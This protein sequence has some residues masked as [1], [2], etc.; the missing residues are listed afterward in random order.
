MESG[1]R[2][3][4]IDV[5]QVDLAYDKRSPVLNSLSLQLPSGSIYGLLGPSGCGKTSLIRCIL[6]LVRVDSG[7]IKVFNRKPNSYGSIVPGV[8][9][10]YMPQDISLF[11]DLSIDE[12]LLYFANLYGLELGACWKRIR[13][14][15]DFLN[16]P[17][18]YRSVGSLSGGQKRRVS[19]A[20]ALIHK[21]PLLIL[22]EPTVGV[23]PLLRTSI[24]SHLT[25]ISHI[26]GMTI[27]IT[28]HY[29]EEA[30]GAHLVGLMRNGRMLVQDNPNRLL[31]HYG[32]DTLEQVFLK[33]CTSA[34]AKRIHDD[35]SDLKQFPAS[36]MDNRLIPFNGESNNRLFNSIERTQSSTSSLNSVNIVKPSKPKRNE[37]YFYN[38]IGTIVKK[39]FRSLIRS[40]GYLL[41]QLLLPLV[42][43][44]LFA[45][46]IGRDLHSIPVAVFDG[47]QTNFSQTILQ[48]IDPSVIDQ[49][50]FQSEFEA[51][52]S[53][54]DGKHSQALIIPDNFAI[55]LY[56]KLND[57]N[58]INDEM[59]YNSTIRILPDMSNKLMID[60]AEKEIIRAY[61][62][63]SKKLLPT[64]G[65]NA[66]MLDMPV[67]L[68]EP[69]YGNANPSFTEFMTPGIVLTQAFF[70]AIS[71]TTMKLVTE[72]NHGLIERVVVTGVSH[73]SIIFSLMLTNLLI[74]LIQCFILLATLLFLFHVPYYGHLAMIY[75]ITVIQSFCGMCFGLMVSAISDTENTATMLSLG[76][77]YPI[78]LLSGAVWPIEAMNDYLRYFSCILPATIPTSSMR[79][80][81]VRGW[82]ITHFEVYSGFLVTLI[83]IGIFLV[84][85]ILVMRFKK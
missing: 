69:V 8:G 79:S 40:R 57:S 59:L 85:S 49:T 48:H 10:G 35:Y 51:L 65:M 54:R 68:G 66:H 56:M 34:K 44:M 13:F 28:T 36:K 17:A 74:V 67:Q 27:L 21:P 41:F 26:D 3:L 76:I 1:E 70:M 72:R 47:D 15:I 20:T 24:W 45:T 12:T 23:D 25:D 83:W 19:L 43:A 71:L 63:T 81:M 5:H 29:I 53:V 80:I 7:S 52:D 61:T 46:T 9:V 58:N 64:M 31:H 50:I 33:L 22:D 6:G 82:S 84:I 14:L 32:L 75:A 4:A 39:N 18:G 77:F 73:F 62:V 2:T 42:E 78:M 37:V 38:H 60:F 11:D 30:K 16:L 55:N